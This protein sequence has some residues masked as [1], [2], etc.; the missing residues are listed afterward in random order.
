MTET[1]NLVELRLAS[2]D[3][4]RFMT[5]V[6]AKWVDDR[7]ISREDHDFVNAHKT[8]CAACADFDAVLSACEDI[9]DMQG[10][11]TSTDQIQK[12]VDRKFSKPRRR[13]LVVGIAAALALALAFV[14]AAALSMRSD[15]SS[16]NLKS[17][18]LTSGALVL[19][20]HAVAVGE[21]FS[22]GKH[23]ADISAD[24]LIE[25][26]G[27]LY[28]AMA[29]GAKIGH[30]EQTDT[31]IR[32]TVDSG[33]I[34]VHLVPSSHLGVLV[35]TAN[36]VV[37][38]KG[39][40][41]IVESDGKKGRVSVVRGKVA[42]RRKIGGAG[43]TEMLAAGW[44]YSFDEQKQSPRVVQSDDRLLE[45]LG[46]REEENAP[47]PSEA[48]PVANAPG[49][50]RLLDT[51]LPKSDGRGRPA[52][53]TLLKAA[54]QCRAAG[55]WRCAADNYTKVVEYYPGLP[56]AATAMI[57][58]AQI[59]LEKLDRPKE[60]LRYFR[61]YQKKRPEGGLSQEALFGECRALREIGRVEAEQDCLT[62]YLEKYPGTLY[63]Q[64]AKSRLMRIMVKD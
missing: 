2:P 63:T 42:V 22:F 53:E 51:V 26:P 3:C 10:Q 4:E 16:L 14:V 36:G 30:V 48:D 38:V 44:T 52:P 61:R 9:S 1:D 21:Q 56:D 27:K 41:F 54:S 5:L 60:A 64:M 62:R 37:E 23:R 47:L 19:E 49:A 45:M 40:V 24:S 39:T 57:P 31:H 58:A 50:G 6:E 8:K 17:F 18:S 11:D 35:E 33:R 15:S 55:D 32:V 34:A 13:Y 7:P 20:G 12:I 28:V 59:L 43:H 25:I 29:K 46:I